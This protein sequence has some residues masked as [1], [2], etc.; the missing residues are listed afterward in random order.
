MPNPSI[1]TAEALLSLH[2]PGFRHELVRG[3]LRRMSAAGHWHGGVVGRL[4]AFLGGHVYERR[5][6]LTYG[7]ETGFVLARKPDTVL[8]P[9]V[10]FVRRALVPRPCSPE[11]GSPGFFPGAPDFAVEVVSPTDT[12]AAVHE[13]ALCWLEHGTRLVWVVEPKAHRVTVYRG[14]EDVSVFGVHDTVSGDD[15]LPD[16]SVAVRALFPALD[17]D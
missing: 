11:I 2:E 4:A 5:L 16:F 1:T 6:G 14:K 7:A 15:V 3:E 12:L 17:A 9:D 13:K 8:A 10:A